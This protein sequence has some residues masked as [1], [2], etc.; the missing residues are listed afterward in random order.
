M[1][2]RLVFGQALLGSPN[3]LLLNE[4][5]NGLDPFWVNKFVAILQEVKKAGIT[6][7]FSTHMMDVAAEVG[8]T[9]LF[10]KERSLKQFVTN[11]IRKKQR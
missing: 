6:I 7:V 8:D 10:M 5:T 2:Q 1:R 3:L 9:I 11:L 4:P